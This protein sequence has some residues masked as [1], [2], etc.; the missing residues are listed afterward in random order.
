MSTALKDRDDNQEL[1]DLCEL[2]YLELSKVDINKPIENMWNGNR[3]PYEAQ[4]P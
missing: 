1:A 4:M 2:R 3:L